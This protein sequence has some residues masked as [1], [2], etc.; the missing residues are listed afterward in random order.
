M[1]SFGS[2]S[3]QALAFPV[4]VELNIWHHVGIAHLYVFAADWNS[5]KWSS[6]S[7][8]PSYVLTWLG[9]LVLGKSKCRIRVT[10]LAVFTLRIYAVSSGRCAPVMMLPWLHFGSLR[11]GTVADALCSFPLNLLN[12][13]PSFRDLG[14]GEGGLFRLSLLKTLAIGDGL[15]ECL[16]PCFLLG[17]VRAVGAAIETATSWAG[18]F[19]AT[20]L[21]GPCQ[22]YAPQSSRPLVD[23]VLPTG[24]SAQ[25]T[26]NGR[27]SA[28]RRMSAHDDNKKTRL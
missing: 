23:H 22:T 11:V 5:F 2:L 9:I 20:V 8:L 18:V 4:S 19:V 12:T 7:P 3:N 27:G 6:G 21:L 17:S 10:S 24:G 14:P 13:S 26:W 16:L 28:V 25:R 1:D 15:R